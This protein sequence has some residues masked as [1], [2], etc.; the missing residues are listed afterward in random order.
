[1]RLVLVLFYLSLAISGFSQSE[2][3][4]FVI[5]NGKLIWQHIYETELT[6]K[7]LI[8]NIKS[9]GNFKNLEISDNEITGEIENLTIDYKGFGLSEMSTPIYIAR[10]SINSFVLFELKEDRYRVT[11]KNIKLIQRYDDGLSKQGDISDLENYA[12]KKKN[13][14]FQNNF[15]NLPSK[16]IDF[17]FKSITEFDVIEKEDDW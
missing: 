16:I 3:N 9:S 5:E 10:T 8:Q 12:L 13:S 2:T 15:L 4:N 17:T 1:M 6:N 14:I 7:Q 11:I